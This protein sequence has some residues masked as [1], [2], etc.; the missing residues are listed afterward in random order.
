MTDPAPDSPPTFPA[1][2]WSLVRRAD[3]DPE[4]SDNQAREKKRKY[5]EN[6]AP[7]RS[8]NG[9]IVL[10]A[11]RAEK[12]ARAK[13][14]LHET[15]LAVDG[16]QRMIHHAATR[17]RSGDV[18]REATGSTKTDRWEK[19]A[20][21]EMFG[22]DTD[23]SDNR[24]DSDYEDK[25]PIPSEEGNGGSSQ[26]SG[27]SA[28]SSTSEVASS[29]KELPNLHRISRNSEHKG[30]VET[31][32]L[33]V[34]RVPGEVFEGHQLLDF[35]ENL[36]LHTTTILISMMVLRSQHQGVGIINPSYQEFAL[37]DQR[38]CI[39]GGYG[40]ANQT[41]DRVTGI[42]RIQNHWA[43][44][45]VNRNINSTTNK[46]TCFM[47]GPMQSEWNYA[48]VVKSVGGVNEE[49]LE[50]MDAVGYSKVKWC[51]QQDGSSCGVWWIAALEMMLNNAP[52]DECIYRLQ[53]YLRMGFYPKA[54]AFV[55]K[56]A[57]IMLLP[58]LEILRLRAEAELLQNRIADMKKRQEATEKECVN[59]TFHVV[60]STSEQPNDLLFGVWKGLAKKSRRLRR[61]ADAE[62]QY[63]CGLYNDQMTTIETLRRLLQMQEQVKS[64]PRWSTWYYVHSTFDTDDNVLAAI[65][66]LHG[67]LGQLFAETDRAFM[68][69]GLEACMSPFAF[70]NVNTTSDT[71]SYIEV[72]FC[73]ILP[74]DHNTVGDCFWHEMIKYDVENAVERGQSQ[75]EA[76]AAAVS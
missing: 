19:D 64:N 68:S 37:P 28:E 29:S 2:T 74:F 18:A 48:I 1:G 13:I 36:W 34:S 31:L 8:V 35:R 42:L 38:R 10:A 60:D 73:R 46:A 56:E 51:R 41:N 59:A 30:Y 7:I 67:D 52:W 70:A 25:A 24:E 44:Y 69:N 72:L 14:D 33:S 21:K 4:N 76:K 43:A 45:L 39:A 53:P 22:I 40:A 66:R 58:K 26:E 75:R 65:N 15:Q 23:S 54:I 62:N 71:T 3:T 32:N 50:L 61:E 12:V 5:P 49:L 47:F 16:R 6:T 57:A 63:L 27:S 11:H 55:E 9:Q 17:L 20:L